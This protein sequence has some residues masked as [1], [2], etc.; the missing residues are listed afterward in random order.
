MINDALDVGKR[1][2]C[3]RRGRRREVFRFRMEDRTESFIDSSDRVNIGYK[4]LGKVGLLFFKD[5]WSRD[6]NGLTVQD[7]RY[8]FRD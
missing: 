3:K 6:L 2:Q 1:D 7:I 4:G 5:T 8:Y